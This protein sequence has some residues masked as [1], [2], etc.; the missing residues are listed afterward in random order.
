M[1]ISGW[2][3]RSQI[4]KMAGIS[5]L[6]E[7]GNRHCGQGGPGTLFSDGFGVRSH[8]ARAGGRAGGVTSGP[9]FIAVD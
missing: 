5:G 4:C 1:V 6:Q 9:G 8:A 3:S 7:S 2:V